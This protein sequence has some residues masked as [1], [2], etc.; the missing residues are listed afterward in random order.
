MN[1][2][3]PRY[4]YAG[5]HLFAA[6]AILLLAD[7]AY[8]TCYVDAHATGHN[9][10]SSWANAYTNLQLAL[11]DGSCTEI[12]VAKGVYT[13]TVFLPSPTISFN[14]LPGTKLYGGFAGDG[15]DS[16]DPAANPTVLSGDIDNNDAHSGD[17]YIDRTSDDIVG[18]NSYHVVMLDGSAGSP[19][20]A[21]TIL[22]GFTITGGDAEG[23]S[24]IDQSGGG[25]F[26]K[27]DGAGHDCSPSIANVRFSGN[28]ARFGAAVY[29]YGRDNGVSSPHF[30]NITFFGNDASV[31]GGAVYIDGDSGESSPIFNNVL[32][33]Q[34]SSANSGGAV[35]MYNS[36]GANN[37]LFSSSTFEE[38]TAL[39][40]SAVD[41]STQA[42]VSN[43]VFVNVTLAGNSSI[44]ESPVFNSASEG[45]KFNLTFRNVTFNANISASKGG[46]IHSLSDSGF[47]SA[48]LVSLSNVVLWGDTFEAGGSEIYNDVGTNSEIDFSIVQDG[49]PPGSACSNVITANPKLSKLRN[50]GGFAPTLRPAI[51]GSPID[52]GSSH[53]CAATDQRG[54]VRSD[55]LCD[56]GAVE[57]QKN[58]DVIFS[59]G[60]ERF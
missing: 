44:D 43:P 52:A 7:H 25:L 41:E 6:A 16:R 28:S 3:I 58:E 27:G 49:C 14:I 24:N 36:L 57:R 29:T 34:N 50:Y 45:G 53:T 19:V 46:A 48:V 33:R 60:F 13:P 26:C 4:S 32:F 47:G 2:Q 11:I 54:F 8:A 38:N 5:R 42:G 9:T 21:S 22:D 17:D 59:D 37:P 35:E 51:D 10:G 18:T 55:G 39:R 1:K 20:E 23:S 15:T 31:F 56:I 40:G 30:D 12:R